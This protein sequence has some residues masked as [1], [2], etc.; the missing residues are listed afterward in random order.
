LRADR[1]KVGGKVGVRGD[2][3]TSNRKPRRWVAQR[4]HKKREDA[5]WIP[6][7]EGE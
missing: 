4:V 6:H 2:Y 1:G 3:E 5:A 7:K